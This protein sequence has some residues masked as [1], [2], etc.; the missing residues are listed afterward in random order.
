LSKEIETVVKKFEKK[1]KVKHAVADGQEVD[2]ATALKMPTLA[3]ALGRISM[4][5]QAPAR[6][7][8]G[9]IV[10]PASQICGQIKGIKDSKKDEAAAETPAA[11]PP[12]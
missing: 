7:I 6:R 1:M 11:T 3:E 12:A 5:A 10:G 2:F 4:L 9:Q 8:A